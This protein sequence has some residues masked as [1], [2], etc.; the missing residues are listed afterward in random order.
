MQLESNEAKG[1]EASEEATSGSEEPSELNGEINKTSPK[2]SVD[3]AEVDVESEEPS[4]KRPRFG[5]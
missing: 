1:A 5:E 3:D 4:S 2:R